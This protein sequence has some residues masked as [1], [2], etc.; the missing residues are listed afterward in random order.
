M[1]SFRIIYLTAFYKA[2]Y[3]LNHKPLISKALPCST[4]D[5]AS[6]VAVVLEGFHRD[7]GLQVRPV[8]IGKEA[9]T[10]R[11]AH[12]FD[13]VRALGKISAVIC[14]NFPSKIE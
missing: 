6:R 5:E 13:G 4:F 14:Q 9:A 3:A 2:N 12:H 11:R 8:V 1:A 7:G 10:L